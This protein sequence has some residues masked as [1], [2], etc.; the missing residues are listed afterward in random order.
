MINKLIFLSVV[1]DILIH[2]DK[3]YNIECVPI[4]KVSMCFLQNPD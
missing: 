3:H 4:W 2:N 1:L